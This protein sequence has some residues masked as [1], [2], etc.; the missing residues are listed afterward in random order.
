M[1][2]STTRLHATSIAKYYVEASSQKRRNRETRMYNTKGKTPPQR[3]ETKYCTIDAGWHTGVAAEGSNGPALR[4]WVERTITQ[5][6]AV[7]CDASLRVQ[8][9]DYILRHF[10]MH[11]LSQ[12]SQSN[13]P[14][15]SLWTLFPTCDKNCAS[16]TEYL[17]ANSNVS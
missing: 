17:A 13:Q 9:A 14:L 15:P 3:N 11:T 8:S 16:N 12:R 4:C 10:R 2:P 6:D 1:R 5:H 7:Q